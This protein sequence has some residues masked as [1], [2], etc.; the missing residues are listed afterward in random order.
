MIKAINIH[1][2]DTVRKI[3]AAAGRQRRTFNP[4]AIFPVPAGRGHFPN[5]D[6]RI[7]IGRKGLTVAAGIGIDNVDFFNHIQIFL[8]RQGRIDVGH[9][10]VKTAAQ[11]GH[12]TPIPETFMVGPLPA[13]FESGGIQGFIVGGIEI[14]NPGG[15][16]GVHDGQIL[17]WQG[18]VD[19]QLRLFAPQQLGQCRHV[20]GI[21]TGRA[22]RA[23]FYLGGNRITL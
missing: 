13:V 22:H 23:A 3:E 1:R 9:A 17:I 10:R 15:Q 6:F 16:T 5:I 14:I 11:K 20:I 12:Q 4:L 21:D 7:K 18:D 2:P 19:H 8:R